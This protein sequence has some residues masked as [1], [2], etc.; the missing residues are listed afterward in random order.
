MNNI[1]IITADIKF[2]SPYTHRVQM[3]C[4]EKNIAHRLT[5]ID[6]Y[7]KPAWFLEIAPLGQVP[8][9]RVED[10]VITDSRSICEYIDN[11]TEPYLLPKD[12]LERAKHQAL[13]AFADEIAQEITRFVKQ[14][15]G[16]IRDLKR[17]DELLGI[18][19]QQIKGTYV[20]GDDLSLVD[21]AFVSHILWLDAL[22]KHIFPF[23]LLRKHEQVVVWFNN[24]QTHPSVLETAGTNFA[25][26]FIEQLEKR[27]LLA[28][29]NDNLSG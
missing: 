25:V 12:A 9:M 27:G 22:E 15:K 2:P 10:T 20:M 11:L 17:L 3:L 7:Q 14:K 23:S 5:A 28:Q 24:L 13:I 1:E 19:N 6:M 21:M 26:N 18:F 16:Q 29:L 4:F 8:V